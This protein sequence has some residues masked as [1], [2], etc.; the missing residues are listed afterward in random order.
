MKRAVF[1]ISILSASAV[2][3]GDEVTWTTPAGS[4]QRLDELFRKWDSL[5]C[6]ARDTT[7]CLQTFGMAWGLEINRDIGGF[8]LD[9]S[10]V[11]N[12][13]P[14]WIPNWNQLVASNNA[15]W[16]VIMALSKAATGR[17]WYARCT[18]QFEL[19]W[20]DLQKRREAVVAA[21]A[22]AKEKPTP[23]EQLEALVA[24]PPGKPDAARF[25]L[26]RAVAQAFAAADRS[27]LY[28]A[29]FASKRPPL[30]DALPKADALHLFCMDAE[31]HG[32]HKRGTGNTRVPII[33]SLPNWVPRHPALTDAVRKRVNAAVAAKQA[34]A[35]ALFA[36][37]VDPQ[38]TDGTGT[39]KKIDRKAGRVT[40]HLYDEEKRSLTDHDNCSTGD[41]IYVREGDRIRA[42]REINCK[43][44]TATFITKTDVVLDETSAELAVG[45]KIQFWGIA[46]KESVK[47]TKKV[48][49]KKRAFDK[50]YIESVWRKGTVTMYPP[51]PGPPPGP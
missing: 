7:A 50:G 8:E 17:A 23:Y 3:A 48:T 10:K 16:D 38:R 49:T 35:D 42:T 25:E 22:T 30:R 14:T 13:D 46:G 12:P 51:P 32:L 18:E 31:V 2:H 5:W 43:S 4:Q 41:R 9:A 44:Y 47:D 34:E 24:I 33:T 37:V 21:I 45:D 27:A 36:A 28:A 40:L 11:Q 20:T 15:R 39:I 29:R 1:L 19:Y 26:E 6:T